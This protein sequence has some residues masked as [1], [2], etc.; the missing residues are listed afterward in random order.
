MNHKNSHSNVREEVDNGSLISLEKIVLKG[1]GGSDP[2]IYNEDGDTKKLK[3]I[4]FF[5][6]QSY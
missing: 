6:S 3:K 2:H 5:H 1:F 4:V